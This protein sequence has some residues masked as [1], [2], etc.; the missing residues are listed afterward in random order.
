MRIFLVFALVLVGSMV[1]TSDVKKLDI[2]LHIESLCPDSL[3]AVTTSFDPALDN[4]L[5][6]M[7][8]VHFNVAGNVTE[9]QIN[10]KKDLYSFQC[11]NGDEEC[12]GNIFE[13]CLINTAKDTLT[14][15]KS[16]VC[17]FQNIKGDKD[18]V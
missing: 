18:A 10:A 12:A 3:H 2:T 5:L 17:M 16:V 11:Q 1:L 14:G 6:E 8:D 9:I 4:G 13:N 15:L 7:A